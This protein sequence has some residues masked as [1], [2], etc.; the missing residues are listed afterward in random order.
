[1]RKRVIGALVKD[2]VA[3]LGLNDRADF[4][5]SQLFGDQQKRVKVGVELLNCPLLLFL[6]GPRS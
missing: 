4:R 6:D 2:T 1:M 5:I 3:K